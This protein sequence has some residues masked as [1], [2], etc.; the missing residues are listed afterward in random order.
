[1]KSS[2]LFLLLAVLVPTAVCVDLAPVLGQVATA[3]NSEEID[4]GFGVDPVDPGFGVR[5]PVSG[6]VDPGFDAPRD[7]ID[8]GFGV[9]PPEITEEELEIYWPVVI[10]KMVTISS[11]WKRQEFRIPSILFFKGW[12]VTPPSHMQFPTLLL[13]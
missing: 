3:D 8:P 2:K 12:E 10:K 5:P 6:P 7:P 4:P 1:M 11:K 13:R 9:A